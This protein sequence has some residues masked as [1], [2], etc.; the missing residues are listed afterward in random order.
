MQCFPSVNRKLKTPDQLWRIKWTAR[1]REWFETIY[2]KQLK[3]YFP[4]HFSNGD[5]EYI[6]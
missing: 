4:I 3:T 6:L 1:R 2:I 5:G